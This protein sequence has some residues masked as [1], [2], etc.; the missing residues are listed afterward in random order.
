M[1]LEVN[2]VGKCHTNVRLLAS[3]IKWSDVMKHVY[4]KTEMQGLATI[5]YTD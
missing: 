1:S 3:Y 5:V 2:I 4:V